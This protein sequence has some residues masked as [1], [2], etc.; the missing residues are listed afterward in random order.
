MEIV[1]SFLHVYAAVKNDSRFWDIPLKNILGS[2]ASAIRRVL[3]LTN[4]CYL[5]MT[6]YTVFIFQVLLYLFIGLSQSGCPS[7]R[8]YF[9]VE[10]LSAILL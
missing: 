9:S 5:A 8:T 4:K 3:V 1:F 7:H 6:C 10:P 2:S